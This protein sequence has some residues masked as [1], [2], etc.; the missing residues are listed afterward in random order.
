MAVSANQTILN[1]GIQLATST[2]TSILVHSSQLIDI[3][4]NFMNIIKKTSK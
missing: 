1:I 4:C 3:E 2:S